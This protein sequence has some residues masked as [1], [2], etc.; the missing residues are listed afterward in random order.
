[1]FLI[2]ITAEVAEEEATIMALVLVVKAVITMAALQGVE[3]NGE[4]INPLKWEQ[5]TGMVEQ[6]H[7]TVGGT[8][9]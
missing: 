7:L 5:V 8:E 6:E 2:A 4:P 1:M 3:A 9:E